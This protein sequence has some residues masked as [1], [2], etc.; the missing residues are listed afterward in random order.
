[1]EEDVHYF[2][3]EFGLFV[4]GG[5][6]PIPSFQGYI[7]QATY[8]RGKAIRADQVCLCVLINIGFDSDYYFCLI[9][10]LWMISRVDCV[11]IIKA[12]SVK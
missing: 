9:I 11:E 2:D 12:Q 10:S 7:G 6:E 3:D 8:Y 5:T 1:M 4:F